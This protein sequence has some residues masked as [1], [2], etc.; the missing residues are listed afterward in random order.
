MKQ[1]FKKIFDLFKSKGIFYTI[2]YLL[3][4]FKNNAFKISL[5]A[6]YVFEIDIK[7]FVNITPAKSKVFIYKLKNQ[8]NDIQDLLD[9]WPEYYRFGRSNSKLKQDIEKY[10]RC[11]DECF[12]IKMGSKIAAMYWVGYQGNHMLQHMAQKDGLNK[13]EAI[14]H[15]AYVNKNCRGYRLQL[16][17]TLHIKD[18]LKELGIFRSRCYTGINNIA[19]IISNMRTYDRYKVLYHVEV[20]IFMFHFN[21]F[22]KYNKNWHPTKHK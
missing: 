2:I 19:A 16:S 6:Y 21:F 9:F 15:R 1:R 4:Y 17:L 8:E 11:G 14:I 22:P 18:H 7:S 13:D 12:C 3:K 5:E 20:D 10:L